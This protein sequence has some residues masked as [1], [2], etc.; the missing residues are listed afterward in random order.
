[1][2]EENSATGGEPEDVAAVRGV[3]H[4]F[5]HLPLH[6]KRRPDFLTGHVGRY[7]E[8]L[9]QVRLTTRIVEQNVAIDAVRVERVDQQE[10]RISVAAITRAVA[11]HDAV[12][13]AEYRLDWAGPMRLVKR[14][15]GW[16][17]VDFVVDGRAALDAIALLNGVSGQA[18]GVKVVVPAIELEA[19]LTTAVLQCTNSSSNL[20]RL[21]R[22]WLMHGRLL[23][24]KWTAGPILGDAEIP[25]S[26]EVTTGAAWPIGL[27]LKTRRLRLVLDL[28]GATKEPRAR[29]DIRVP[30]PTLAHRRRSIEAA[31]SA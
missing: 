18:D 16:R 20:V 21:E 23:Q 3:V 31:G 25:P 30:I 8:L 14:T 26:T 11:E 19:P 13:R 4:D 1:V 24:P 9:R 29:I 17:I 27:D 12:G 22:A 7:S 10:A 6:S 15:E 5:L 28:S 2:D